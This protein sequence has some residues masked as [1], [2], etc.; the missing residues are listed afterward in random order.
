MVE[1][2]SRSQLYL[3]FSRTANVTIFTKRSVF[4]VYQSIYSIQKHLNACLVKKNLD[5]LLY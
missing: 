4:I 5:Y 3:S 2:E 1:T